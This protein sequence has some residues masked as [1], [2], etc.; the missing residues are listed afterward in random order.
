[1]SAPPVVG[2]VML[3]MEADAFQTTP[4]IRKTMSETVSVL[5]NVS[6]R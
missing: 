6:V 4:E 2:A 3:G 5:R 1:L